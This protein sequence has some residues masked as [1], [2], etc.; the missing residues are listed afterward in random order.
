[1]KIKVLIVI[2]ISFVPTLYLL[3]DALV[4]TEDAGRIVWKLIGAASW[5]LLIITL[6][7]Y[8][9]EMKDKATHIESNKWFK[10]REA[11]FL[12]VHT[13][14]A[15]ERIY[16]TRSGR[17]Y[18]EIK[19]PIFRVTQIPFLNDNFDEVVTI[20]VGHH[21]EKISFRDSQEIKI[22]SKDSVRMK[23]D[24]HHSV[25]LIP[26]KENIEYLL[27]NTGT[28]LEELE[29][30]IFESYKNV[31]ASFSYNDLAKPTNDIK[32]RIF[33]TLKEAVSNERSVFE[34][35][36]LNRFSCNAIDR[37]FD[38]VE[39]DIAFQQAKAKALRER[40]ESTK[41]II[42]LESQE[43]IERAKLD[44]QG[45]ILKVEQEAELQAKKDKIQMDKQQEYLK[46]LS[47]YF[48]EN[49]LVLKY[50]VLFN[51]NPELFESVL[52]RDIKELELQIQKE[53]RQNEI[54]KEFMFRIL[55]NYAHSPNDTKVNQNFVFNK[56]TKD[57]SEPDVEE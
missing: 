47:E 27:S 7:K 21:V 26:T 12:S 30:V 57:V 29:A 46:A 52:K 5:A 51:I 38:E 15:T 10:R 55:S 20:F 14:N 31:F 24:A 44:H 11:K 34:V 39:E 43:S 56:K 9:S 16:L 50:L 32:K 18:R 54:T 8:A 1:M 45:N 2:V 53:E 6:I 3:V 35:K 17:L 13:A 40:I 37:D 41:K 42:E 19:E 48:G 23:C 33:E 49:S 25:A 22:K 28:C 4:Y 36:A